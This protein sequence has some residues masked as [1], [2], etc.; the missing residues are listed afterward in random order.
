MRVF[1]LLS[2]LTM[3]LI[4][5]SPDSTLVPT[6]PDV[7]S[8]VAVPKA[9]AES[10]SDVP[11]PPQPN[12]DGILSLADIDFASYSLDLASFLNLSIGESKG[13]VED[14]IHAVF[15]PRKDTETESGHTEYS[16]TELKAEGGS[17]T[18]ATAESLADD[19][20]KAQQLYTIFKDDALVTYGMKIK[21][22]RGDDTEDWQKT[23]CP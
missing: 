17:V 14:K 18:V 6:S 3:A 4:G 2:F 23:P 5:C 1:V 22:W 21:C 11:T 20:V 19:S 9:P 13:S 16:L 10:R 15:K 8:V 12:G 7:P